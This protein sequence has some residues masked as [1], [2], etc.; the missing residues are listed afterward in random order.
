MVQ[1]IE[2]FRENEIRIG[3]LRWVQSQTITYYTTHHRGFGKNYTVFFLPSPL[4]WVQGDSGRL[5]VAS[6]CSS[7]TKLCGFATMWS[8]YQ[9]GPVVQPQ[10]VLE[11]FLGRLIS[12]CCS[13]WPGLWRWSGTNSG[14]SYSMA[15]SGGLPLT[16]KAICPLAATAV[17]VLLWPNPWTVSRTFC[18]HVSADDAFI[19]RHEEFR[20]LLMRLCFALVIC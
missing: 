19:F 4:V 13:R 7:A 20:E 5:L 18:W 10:D 6:T 2:F 17:V 3:V 14:S 11:V 8:S 1:P 15:V 9:Q 12:N 16:F